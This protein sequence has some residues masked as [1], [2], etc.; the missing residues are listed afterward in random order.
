V[1]LV[2]PVLVWS[3]PS[4]YAIIKTR[5]QCFIGELVMSAKEAGMSGGCGKGT[6][7]AFADGT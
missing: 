1:V 7:D 2:G 4:V 5:P 3:G 6:L